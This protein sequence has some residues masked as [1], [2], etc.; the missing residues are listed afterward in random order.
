MCSIGAVGGTM[1]NL[2]LYLSLDRRVRAGGGRASPVAGARRQP[3][4]PPAHGV[5]RGPLARKRVML[6]IYVIVAARDSAAVR[7]SHLAGCTLFAAAFGIGLGGD[8]MIIPLM[9]ADLF[10]VQRSGGVMGIVLTADGVGGS[11]GADVVARIRDRTR[12]LRRRLPGAD[13]ACRRRRA[14]RDGAAANGGG[15]P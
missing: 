9:A 7:R 13:R 11:R 2:K 10:G 4:R 8:Y 14:V 5:A 15:R 6:L 1:Q 12:Q 3:R